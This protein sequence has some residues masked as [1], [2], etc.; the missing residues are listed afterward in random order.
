MREKE[1]KHNAEF[2]QPDPNKETW[3]AIS[4]IKQWLSELNEQCAKILHNA[5]N[6]FYSKQ[7]KIDQEKL[8]PEEKQELKIEL[9]ELKQRTEEFKQTEQLLINK[10][11]D[12]ITGAKKIISAQGFKVLLTA[13]TLSTITTVGIYEYKYP[14]EVKS[15]FLGISGLQN[16]SVTE[17]LDSNEQMLIDQIKKELGG[18]WGNLAISYIN[19]LDS[20]KNTEDRQ[21]LLTTPKPIIHVENFNPKETGLL[22]EIIDEEINTTMPKGFSF[23][24]NKITH[25]LDETPQNGELFYGSDLTETTASANPINKEITLFGNINNNDQ[26]R[27]FLSTAPHE[28]THLNDW[29]SNTLLSRKERLEILLWALQRVETDDRVVFNYVEEINPNIENVGQYFKATEYFANIVTLYLT[30]PPEMFKNFNW[31][32]SDFKFIESF[33]KKMDPNF[34]RDQQSLNRLDLLKKLTENKVL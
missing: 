34:D 31:S 1:P 30:M 9:E 28:V 16:L 19:T 26:A 2:N 32:Q 29:N 21:K 18:F 4:K 25:C 27:I 8:T 3:F 6:I 22:G 5:E 11:K 33:I 24:V 12:T 13:L 17:K 23:N 15:L 14:R 10:I 7:N 20:V